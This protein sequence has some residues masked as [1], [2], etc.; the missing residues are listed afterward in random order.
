LQ[1]VAEQRA[2]LER[3]R[4][5]VIRQIAEDQ[6]NV[7]NSQGA[8]RQA[9]QQS[10]EADRRQLQAIEAQLR[11]LQSFQEAENQNQQNFG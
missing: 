7:Q 5:S 3:Q 2:R 6:E 1:N 10:L 8:A 11:Q 9:A 4:Q